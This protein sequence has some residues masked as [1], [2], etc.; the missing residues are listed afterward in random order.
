MLAGV[1]L[2]AGAAWA[3]EAA[4]PL[5][6]PAQMSVRAA[7]AMLP[8]LALAGQRLVA[9]GEHGIIVYS[10]NRGAQWTQAQVPVS[11]TLTALYFADPLHGYAVGH[12]GAIL[13]SRDG[14]Q[15]WTLQLDGVAINAMMLADARKAADLAHAALE[16]AGDKQAAQ[17]AADRA[18]NALADAE[19]AGKFGPSRPLLAVWFRNASEG[20]AVG[21]YGQALQTRDGGAHW[22]SAASRIPNPEGLHYNAIGQGADGALLIAGE[23]GKVYRSGDAGASWEVFDTGYKGQLYGV[24]QAAPDALLAYGFGGHVLRSADGGRSWAALP[25]TTRQSLIGA[26]SA[27]DGAL[28]L[29][30][31]D[32]GVLRSTDG[33]R[34]FSEAARGQAMDVA[35]ARA[36]SAGGATQLALSGM[37]GVHLLGVAQ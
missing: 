34:S 22:V 24:V 6:T 1:L 13:A 10:D 26:A 30:A 5:H 16:R 4:D 15:H 20:W 36:L 12:D 28:L 31:R 18:D 17:A 37:G 29:V 33:G 25:Q 2:A 32:G 35:S 27:A 19:A 8:G 7:R 3:L 23:G 21:A 14:G 9:A 11:V